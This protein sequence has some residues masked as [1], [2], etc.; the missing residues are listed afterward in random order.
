MAR[1]RSTTTPIIP[2]L[3]SATVFISEVSVGRKLQAKF[4]Q[5]ITFSPVVINIKII[6]QSVWFWVRSKPYVLV[7][8]NRIDDSFLEFSLFK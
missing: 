2:N 8:N 3:P 1:K 7:I 4:I 5:T 6:D